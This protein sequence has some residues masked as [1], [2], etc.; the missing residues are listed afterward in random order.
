MLK[1]IG[2]RI[3]IYIYYKTQ[4][5]YV[6]LI[7][8]IPLNNAVQ[9]APWH[10]Y[11][12]NILVSLHWKDQRSSDSM[13]HTHCWKCTSTRRC[14]CVGGFLPWAHTQGFRCSE[15]QEPHEGIQVFELMK[16][17]SMWY[18]KGL[19]GIKPSLYEIL[20][21]PA[22]DDRDIRRHSVTRGQA[23]H[24]G[25]RNCSSLFGLNYTK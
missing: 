25:V 10:S 21:Q 15:C 6:C 11:V 4:T 20:A 3:Y 14:P 17:I 5:S 16:M 22:R 1:Q 8:D 23:G 24:K 18:L 12:P 13:T 2:S 7:S 9:H 19:C